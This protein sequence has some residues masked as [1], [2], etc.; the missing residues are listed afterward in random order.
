MTCCRGSSCLRPGHAGFGQ[1]ALCM[2]ALLD[3]LALHVPLTPAEGQV[4]ADSAAAEEAA[5][6][7]TAIEGELD[8]RFV[9]LCC[10]QLGQALQVHANAV[11]RSMN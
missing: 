7:S 9:Q 5:Q 3:E 1:P 2:R 8:A 11:L 10:P 6:R 4:A